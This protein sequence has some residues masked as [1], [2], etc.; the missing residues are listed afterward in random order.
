MS[1]EQRWVHKLARSLHGDVAKDV[2]PDGANVKCDKC[3]TVLHLDVAACGKALA[4]G[5]PKCCGETMQML[6]LGAA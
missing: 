2:W 3:G 5:W 1:D 6:A 4:A